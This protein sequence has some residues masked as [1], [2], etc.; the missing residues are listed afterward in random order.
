MDGSAILGGLARGGGKFLNSESPLKAIND[1]LG[2]H[3]ELLS[4]YAIGSVVKWLCKKLVVIDD[5]DEAF[6]QLIATSY[7]ITVC[8]ALERV[9][10][11]PHEGFY[12][13]AL[14]LRDAVQDSSAASFDIGSSSRF[15]ENTAVNQ[16]Q[17]A[18][19][20]F[21]KGLG[22]EQRASI[23]E[24]IRQQL[25][26]NYH[27]TLSEQYI[28]FEKYAEYVRSTGYRLEN[29]KLRL[30]K[31]KAEL[32]NLY[33]Q[34]IMQDEAGLRLADIYIEPG[35]KVHRACFPDGDKRCEK[36]GRSFIDLSEKTGNIHDYLTS[37]LIGE[38]SLTLKIG[39]PQLLFVL[40]FPGQGK[41]SLCRR[42]LHDV[43]TKQVIWNRAVFYVPLRELE[44]SQLISAPLETIKHYLC[45]KIKVDPEALDIE[46]SLLIIDGLDEVYMQGVKAVGI[47]DFCHKLAWQIR[48]NTGMKVLV[49]SRNGYVDIVKL[50]CLDTLILQIRELTVNQQ[51][52]WLEIYRKFHA[53]SR[54]TEEMIDIIHGD[55]KYNHIRE[56]IEQP[57][58][59]H[60]VVMANVNIDNDSV[61]RA[62]IYN[63][64]FNTLVNRKWAEG[65]AVEALRGTKAIDLRQLISAIALR[66]FQTGE[67]YITRRELLKLE[68]VK[69]FNAK[70]GDGTQFTESLKG[71]LIAFYLQESQQSR[72]DG[73]PRDFIIEFL[74]KSL[75]EYL[76]AE[77]LWKRIK[78]FGEKRQSG[79]FLID[80]VDSA[81]SQIV[82]LFGPCYLS[83]EVS[84]YLCQIIDNDELSDKHVIFERLCGF[85]DG[86][87][88]LDFFGGKVVE[89]GSLI[90]SML[91]TFYG[92]WVTLTALKPRGI[93]SK[94][95]KSRWNYISTDH[96]R[97]FVFWVRCLSVA[98]SLVCID[99]CHQSLPGVDFERLDLSDADLSGTDLVGASLSETDLTEANLHKA[100][101]TEANLY[102][103]DLSLANLS[104]A[105]LHKANLHKADLTLA[106]LQG[107]DLWGADLSEA[108]LSFTSLEGA[109]LQE[110][111]LRGALLNRSWACKLK[112]VNLEGVKW[113]DVPNEENNADGRADYSSILDETG[114]Q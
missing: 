99:L 65:L 28:T 83:Q 69:K 56:L 58:L 85:M 49:T 90:D 59:L 89:G 104:E 82:A 25:E 13:L 57:I 54:L 87:L 63:E 14:A 29:Q 66:I 100:D 107:A 42:L 76:A 10:V 31:Y 114:N 32:K 38:N 52:K 35:F 96:V 20:G 77:E 70:L 44:A 68:E 51:K 2:A 55:S 36:K 21:L 78:E 95:E 86:L 53:E 81:L 27:E 19:Q 73:I 75:Q 92:Y 109:N 46:N 6:R 37:L 9:G 64:L 26:V 110:A 7:F 8:E 33:W 39:D 3:S 18:L 113:F 93:L 16:C 101:L 67:G 105:I 84:D 61:N 23:V 88:R 50:S 40:G 94:D 60:M 62:Q 91:A 45:Q 97:R 71:V 48:G 72:D 103:A 74:H 11:D 102:K 17:A 12:S 43:I 79:E 4:G 41:T 106:N 30:S 80:C 98:N 5:I 1:L 24:Y 111:D 47:D 15:F 34:T 108:D 112:T 22:A